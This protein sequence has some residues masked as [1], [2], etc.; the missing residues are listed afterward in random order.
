[1][2]E[3]SKIII[4]ISL[5]EVSLSFTSCGIYGK[6]KSPVTAEQDSIKTPSYKDIF[7]D[8]YLIALIDTALSRNYDVL[9]SHEIVEQAKASLLGA[10]MAYIPSIAASPS[11]TWT[12]QGGASSLS[13]GIAQASWEIDI[14]GRLTNKMR[15]AKAS[16]KEAEAYE[17]AVRSEIIATVAE[18][19]YTLLMLDAQIKTADS[20]IVSWK[21]SVEAQKSFKQAGSSDEAA[22]AQFEANLY[23]TM[24]EAKSLRLS[25]V[26]AESA[27]DV[28][29]A[30][31]VGGVTP[32]STLLETSLNAGVIESIDLQA[33]RIRPDV[34]EAEYQLEQAFYA[35]NLSRAN[36]CPDI[37]ISG[38]LGWNGGLIFSAVGSLLQPILN[39]GK[40]ISAVRSAKH[41]LK[42]AEYSYSKA[43][44]TAAT[45]VN[46]AMASQKIHRALTIDYFNQVESLA[47]AFDMT[48]TKMSLGR[49]TYLEVLTAQQSLLT[50]QYKLISNYMEVLN[51]GVELFEALGGR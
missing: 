37:S 51:A 28:L 4:A 13:Y 27:M 5:L 8:P 9:V 36:W 46:N 18:T 10:K 40:N 23:S 14:F 50:A 1:M 16:K 7:N 44:L 32:R 12:T 24:A 15:I 42:A 35:L 11:V 20:A 22:V 34:R 39:S 47:R 30:R 26:E 33:V 48:K 41:G 43:L 6:F 19:Y 38:T 2:K 21:E 49:G 45:E 25:L 3:L 29:L 31:E 17:Q